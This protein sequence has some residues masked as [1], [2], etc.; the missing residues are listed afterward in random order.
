MSSLE[1]VRRRSLRL[2]G[3][4]AF[5]LGLSGCLRPLYG[6]TAS[7]ERLDQV[8]AAVQVNT[9]G[10]TAGQERLGHYVRSELAFDLNGSGQPHVKRYAL[11]IAVKERVQTAVV[12]TATGRAEAATIVAE[13]SYA[14]AK[15]DGGAPVT[16]GVAVGSATYDRNPQR[17]ATVRASRDAEIRVAKL[18]ADQIRIRLS[19]ALATTP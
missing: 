12:D 9:V 4:A 16:S 3:A 15:L 8:L 2:A 10:V 14:L 19:A 1:R 13:A 11:T 18:L 7:G 5:I 6:P 17:F